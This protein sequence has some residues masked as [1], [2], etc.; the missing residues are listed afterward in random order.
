MLVHRLLYNDH[1]FHDHSG[2]PVG[3]LGSETL[4][5]ALHPLAELRVV[6]PPLLDSRGDPRA[7]ERNRIDERFPAELK[8]L[9][10]GQWSRIRFIADEVIRKHP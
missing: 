10:C 7:E 4:R 9:R 8:F 6:V 5:I 2:Y 1:A 3:V